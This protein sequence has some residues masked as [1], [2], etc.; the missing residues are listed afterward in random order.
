MNSVQEDRR[1]RPLHEPGLV[2]IWTRSESSAGTRCA[3]L[4]AMKVSSFGRAGT[5]VLVFVLVAACGGQVTGKSSSSSSSGGSSGSSSSGGSSGSSGGTCS[6]S[7][8]PGDRTCVPGVARANTPIQIVVDA[9]EGCLPCFA[10]FEPCAV[11]VVGDEV[12]VSMVTKTCLPS[13]DTGCPA[14]C[15]IP[16]TTCTL[17]PL[18]AGTYTVAVTGEGARSPLAPRRLEVATE[19]TATSCTLPMPGAPPPTLDGSSYSTSCSVDDDC[20][21]AIVGTACA[22]C[23]CPNFA[24]AKSSARAYE[25]DYREKTSQCATRKEP[26]ACAGCPATPATC[27]KAP[28][29]LTGTCSSSPTN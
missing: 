9:S 8:L 25:A 1:A 28:D 26:V 7:T 3:P 20:V 27:A 14:I 10:T 23:A 29:A 17:P 21:L 6:T 2:T 18:A 24:I 19:A 4:R 11:S 12:T 16:R 22:P 13:G 15:Q 5:V